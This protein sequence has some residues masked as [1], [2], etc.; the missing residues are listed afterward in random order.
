MQACE[1]TPGMSVLAHG[2]AVHDY[3]LDLQAYVQGGSRLRHEWRLPDWITTPGL[4]SRLAPAKILEEYQVFH[5]NGK[6]FCRTT[7]TEGRVHFPDH[8]AWSEA[9]WRQVGT[10]QAARLMGMDMDVHLL[11]G[12]G[13]VDF[14]AKPEA[15]SLLITGFCEVHANAAM[16]GG[17]ESTSF[18][19]KWKHLDRR[20]KQICKLLM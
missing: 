19:M 4:W 1:Q 12:E 7:D 5:D 11:K 3:F 2:Q 17:I 18:K 9:I 13:V 6:P 10:E 20:G 8:A 16:F 14:A 15:A